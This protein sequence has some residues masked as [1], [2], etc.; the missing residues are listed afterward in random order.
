[1]LR[2]YANDMTALEEGQERDSQGEKERDRQ[3][4]W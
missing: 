4:W 3:R 1:M 2:G